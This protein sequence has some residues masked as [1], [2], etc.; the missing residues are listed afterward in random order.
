MMFPAIWSN[1]HAV[2]LIAV[3]SILLTL[4]V[5]M[6]VVGLPPR[7]TVYS[8]MRTEVGAAPYDEQQIFEEKTPVDSLFVGSSLLVRGVDTD[9]VQSELSKKLGR[10]ATVRYVALKWH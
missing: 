6:G 5:L 7:S 1:R 9:Y 8:G 10:P 3:I 2:A 4:P